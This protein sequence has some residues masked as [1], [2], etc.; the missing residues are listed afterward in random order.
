MCSGWISQSAVF[1]LSAVPRSRAGNSSITRQ[2]SPVLCSRR[3]GH[4]SD[5]NQPGAAVTSGDKALTDSNKNFCCLRK[6][7]CLWGG[8]INVLD[9]GLTFS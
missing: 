7:L 9:A 1:G 4:L 8:F 2:C 3:V 5:L 6:Q